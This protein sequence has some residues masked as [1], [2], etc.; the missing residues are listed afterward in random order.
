MTRF[1]RDFHPPVRRRIACHEK[2]LPSLRSGKA[3]EDFVANADLT[4][5]EL[6]AM[7]TIRF[8]FQLKRARV[9]MRLPKPLLTAVKASVA[10]AVT[11]SRLPF[12]CTNRSP[13][14]SSAGSPRPG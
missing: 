12:P 8:E 14:S 10:V 11:V 13:I 1:V 4:D 6:S 9:N 7:R 5:C 2:K 3:M